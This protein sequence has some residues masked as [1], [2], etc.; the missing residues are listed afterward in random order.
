MRPGRLDMMREAYSMLTIFYY[1]AGIQ[2]EL[3]P[4][5]DQVGLRKD[6]QGV[7]NASDR[8]QQA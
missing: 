1:N 4:N 3:H 5:P 2:T 8:S 6:Q 7:R